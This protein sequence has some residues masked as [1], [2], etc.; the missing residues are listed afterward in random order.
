MIRREYT[1]PDFLARQY[2]EADRL[3]ARIEFHARHSETPNDWHRF[4]LEIVN[5]GAG[6]DLLDA[7]CGDGR[8]YHPPLIK[9]GVR[10]FAIDRSPGM[11]RQAAAHGGSVVVREHFAS[12]NADWQRPPFRPQ[13]R[14]RRMLKLSA[15]GFELFGVL[16][17]LAGM[18][19]LAMALHVNPRL[20]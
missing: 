8:D 1:D 12:D 13:L 10:L 20:P 16:V 18:V 4:L 6:D 5:A 2:S 14:T 3:R 11:V 19:V 15:F 9:A 17:V 7:G